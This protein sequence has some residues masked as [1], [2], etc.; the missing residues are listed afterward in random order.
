MKHLKIYESEELEDDDDIMDNLLSILRKFIKN[1]GYDPYVSYDG[2]SISVDFI[3]SQ[4]ETMPSLMKVMNLLNKL[5]T[6]I[7]IQYECDFELA[8]TT[9]FMPLLTASFYYSESA[10]RKSRKKDND[11][12]DK[13]ISGDK[14]PF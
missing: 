2:E 4:T 9:D 3:L 7:L 6:D 5:H 8:E 12:D 10:T 1:A 14:F 11:D 13:Y